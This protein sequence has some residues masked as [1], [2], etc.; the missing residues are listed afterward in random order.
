MYTFQTDHKK[1]CHEHALTFSC[2][3]GNKPVVQVC[4]YKQEPE[5]NHWPNNC[6]QRKNTDTIPY[7]VLLAEDDKEMRA[8]LAHSLLRAGFEVVDCPDG[9]DLIEHIEHQLLFGD[10]S[11][12]I[13]I[14]VSDI[15]MPG[16]SGIEVL[17]GLGGIEG[18]PPMVLI[19]A[20]GDDKTHSLALKLGAAAIFDKPF[21]VDELLVKVRKILNA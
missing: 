19:T 2:P 12:N 13:D 21:D 6:R 7:R 9:W 16:P 4:G 1:K 3:G 20:F 10:R 8:L 18:F 14:I 11:E 17:R 15:R 5:G